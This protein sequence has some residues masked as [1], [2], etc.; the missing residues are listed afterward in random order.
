MLPPPQADESMP[1]RD[2]ALF[3]AAADLEEETTAVLGYHLVTDPAR[4]RDIRHKNASSHV[5]Y[6]VART[7]K[8]AAPFVADT[9]PNDIAKF[10]NKQLV[11]KACPTCKR[12]L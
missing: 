2:R 6:A 1:Q 7:A 11:V 3:I 4:G 10:I 12:P 8:G 9:A 5:I